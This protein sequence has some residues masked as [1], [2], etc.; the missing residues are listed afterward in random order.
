LPIENRVKANG[1]AA[2]VR[3]VVADDHQS[4]LERVVAILSNEFTVVGTAHDG[5]QL[6][7]AEAALHPD[8]LVVDISMPRMTGLE[9]TA[10]IRRR[11]S[12][13]VVVCLTAHEE[14]E[15]LE[16]ALQVGALGFV[17]KTCLAYDLVP[18][19]HAALEGRSFVS[20]LGASATPRSA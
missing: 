8:V 5:I 14:G 18:A 9:A 11:G 10:Q 19:I 17:T 20:R 2:R 1:S 7:D 3:V 13:V 12:D 6:L 4:L 15:L 16:A